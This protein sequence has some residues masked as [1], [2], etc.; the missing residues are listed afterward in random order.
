MALGNVKIKR[1]GLMNNVR[2]LCQNINDLILN[3]RSLYT[4]NT[5]YGCKVIWW[6]RERD[7]TFSQL[8]MKRCSRRAT[9]V[10]AERPAGGAARRSP[11]PPLPMT[12]ALAAP[13]PLLPDRPSRRAA[14][15]LSLVHVPFCSFI[16]RF[17]AVFCA[18]IPCCAPLDTDV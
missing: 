7:F 18:T 14:R 2:H 1:K 4:Y 13:L 16:R 10:P 9:M 6:E 5:L 11:L 12:H 8:F 15:S 17:C 3:I